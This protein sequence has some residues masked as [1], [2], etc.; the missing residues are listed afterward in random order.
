M[1]GQSPLLPPVPPLPSSPSEGQQLR[2]MRRAKWKNRIGTVFN[3]LLMFIFFSF[4]SG[5]VTSL[6]YHVGGSSS[7]AQK[8]PQV[9]RTAVG[10]TVPNLNLDSGGI[11]SGFYFNLS[12]DYRMSKQIGSRSQILGSLQG[13][14]RFNQLW[15]NR[16]WYNGAHRSEI[17]FQHPGVMEFLT[18]EDL[19][20]QQQT[21]SSIWQAL[22]ML[23]EG[24][25]SELAISLDGT[26]SLNE[27]YNMFEEYDMDIVWYAFETGLEQE[28]VRDGKH[29]YGW[30][31]GLWGMSDHLMLYYTDYQGGLQVRGDGP[32]K[33]QAFLRGLEELK[34]HE[35][36]V[37][38]IVYGDLEL[39]KRID[40][41][42]EHGSRSYGVIV[43][44][45]TKELL[46]LREH[47]HVTRP[48]LG[49]TD[50]WNWYQT[51]FSSTQH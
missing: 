9:L 10:M 27:I 24:T 43:T 36:W 8:L 23:P 22:E 15:V 37:R 40:Y 13:E 32:A 7:T 20:G 5:I 19:R 6:L 28:N 29:L 48:A 17:Y 47:P 30:G 21:D 14:M 18:E 41:V 51:D 49:E 33:E 35:R 11:S 16:E 25:V 45:P 50:W 3:L 44:G 42:S 31:G 26:Y 1:A 2:W 12:M 34:K 46:K 38:K 4:L 39:Q